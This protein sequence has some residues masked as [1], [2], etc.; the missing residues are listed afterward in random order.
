MTTDSVCMYFHMIKMDPE[1]R[2]KLEFA[3]RT[4][5]SE[6]ELKEFIARAMAE[7]MLL[8]LSM[9][10]DDSMNEQRKHFIDTL[11]IL[12]GVATQALRKYQDK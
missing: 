9:H 2:K 10:E 3:L 8:T 12:Q 1:D 4:E 7:R 6:E 11:E 5:Y